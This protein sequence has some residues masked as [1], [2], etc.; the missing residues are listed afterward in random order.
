MRTISGRNTNTV[1]KSNL[2]WQNLTSNGLVRVKHLVKDLCVCVF[3]HVY[4]YTE[5]REHLLMD[6]G[7]ADKDG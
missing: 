1:R 3:V 6:E 5:G 4:Y 2:L 7:T